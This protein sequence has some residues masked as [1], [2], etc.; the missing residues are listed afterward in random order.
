[1][2]NFELLRRRR[3]ANLTQA[4]LSVKAGLHQNTVSRI[5]RGSVVPDM[6]TR[7]KLAEAL[8]IPVYD[9]FP[10]AQQQEAAS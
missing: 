8:G 4:E 1:M 5:E 10:P 3:L 2:V 7:E 6:T 9:L